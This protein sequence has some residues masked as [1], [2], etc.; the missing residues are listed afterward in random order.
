MVNL[1]FSSKKAKLIYCILAILV[2]FFIYIS[3]RGDSVPTLADMNIKIKKDTDL[4]IYTGS[5]WT[6]G[7]KDKEGFVEALK[8]NNYTLRFNPDTTQI[9]VVDNSSDFEWRSNP[10]E[11]KLKDETVKGLLLSNLRSPFI[12]EYFQTQGDDK[13]RREITNATN[14]KL[15]K[16]F[17]MYEKGLQVTYLLTE[18]QLKFSV[19]Y[20]LTEKGLLV[21]VPKKG[22]EERS[23]F[24]LY[25]L[26]ILPY[27]GASQAG[28]DGYLF[29]PDGP[30]GLIHFNENRS[31]LSQGYLHQVYGR[32]VSNR[33]NDLYNNKRRTRVADV[34]Y[35]VFGVKYKD[36]AFLTILGMGS[37][38]AFIK[39]MP[40][41]LKSSYYNINASFSYRE[42]YL[43]KQ[44]RTSEPVRTV[45]KS[46]LPT[47]RTIEYRFLRGDQANYTGMA[48]AYQAYLIETQQLGSQMSSVK[49]I[50]MDLDIMGGDSIMAFN[51]NQYIATT[52]FTQAADIIQT[53]KAGGVDNIRII[54]YGWQ[55]NGGLNQIN[56]LPIESLLGGEKAAKAFVD[57]VHELNNKVLFENNFTMVTPK[58]SS[59]SAKSNG[60]RG[61]DETVYFTPWGDFFLKPELSAGYA[62]K[63]ITKLKEIGVDGILYNWY[64]D[65]IYRDFNTNHPQQRNDIAKVYESAMTY[66]QKQLGQSGIYQGNEYALKGINQITY[67]PID[68]NYDLMVDDTVPFYPIALHGYISYSATPGNLRNDYEMDFLKAVEYGAVP[69]FFMSYERSRLLKDSPSDFLVSSEFT[70]WKDRIMKE[71]KEFD[72]L[73]SVYNQKIIRHEKQTENVYMTTYEDGTK[74]TVDYGRKTFGVEKGGLHENP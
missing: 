45:E 24:S 38:S 27:F 67:F 55:D 15:E 22:I 46:L 69:A 49:H 47:D 39:A 34:T 59:I 58:F 68:S 42:E 53:L 10:Q 12:L 23:N 30:G 70:V 4:P 7:A 51:R 6:A 61:I 56:P 32:E 71:Y 37:D 52:T 18:L 2:L 3:L 19:Q 48:L 13:A 33:R 1:Q 50:P 28:E 41:G 35:P 11:E 73:A 29:V 20:E 60:V 62:F 64:G 44:S 66:G 63:L 31:N 54:Y 5:A 14:K 72:K 65:T 74:V 36:Q 16:T 17:L 8:N 57:K 9:I 26:D 25:S 21:N 40:P 43:R